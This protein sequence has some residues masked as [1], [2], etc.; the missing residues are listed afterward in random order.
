MNIIQNTKIASKFFLAILIFAASPALAFADYG[1]AG[2]ANTD[3]GGLDAGYANT[4]SYDFGGYANPV[5]YGG[6][7]NA[8]W[9][10][11][12]P[13]DTN[14]GWANAQPTDTNAGF[15]NT[16]PVDT[17]AG[18]AN[19]GSQ[20][21]NAGF[22]NTAPVDTNAGF[23]NTRPIDTNAGYANAGS[24]DTNA[25]FAN[26][27]PFDTFAGYANTEN[28][29][30]SA[31]TYMD[32]Y[33]SYPNYYDT[34]A[35]YPYAPGFGGGFGPSF[36]L[37]VGFGVAPRFAS[38][39]VYSS[40]AIIQPAFVSSAPSV[41]SASAS[42]TAVA[43]VTNINTVSAPPQ[44]QAQ[45][46]APTYVTPT[47]YNPPQYTAQCFPPPPPPPPAP[48][49]ALTQIPYTGIDGSVAYWLTLIGIVA[50]AAYSLVYFMPHLFTG[51]SGISALAFAGLRR[52]QN[53]IAAPARLIEASI[54]EKRTGTNDSMV[55]VHSKDGPRIVINRN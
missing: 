54:P 49:V 55:T 27:A 25:G 46:V 23:A 38:P 7:T 3:F 13:L 26:T 10:N 40:P 30:P 36:G 15:A 11:T 47:Y 28:Y 44:Y 48:Y 50:A 29:P 8:G 39:I 12:Q 4:G 16:S 53:A 33:A 45:Y 14:A 1:D 51:K 20:D 17:N 43:S 6:D 19:V 21:T 34:Y 37:G 35:S 52:K 24:Q 18:Y 42:A 31:P 22:A 9:A 5:S 32:T 41:S 2:F